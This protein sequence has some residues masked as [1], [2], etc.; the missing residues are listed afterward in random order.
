MTGLHKKTIAFDCNLRQRALEI[1]RIAC[2]DYLDDNADVA[3]I[4]LDELHIDSDRSDQ[5]IARVCSMRIAYP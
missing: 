1:E 2:R 3:D 5:A 4:A